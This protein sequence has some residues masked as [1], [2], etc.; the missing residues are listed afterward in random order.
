MLTTAPS[1][2]SPS[3]AEVRG[4]AVRDLA[5]TGDSQWYPR[6]VSGTYDVVV[7]DRGRFVIPRELRDRAGLTDGTPLTLVETAQGVVM[8]TRSQLRD[9]VRRDLAGLDLVG[10]LL[11]E[12]RSAA[13]AED[14]A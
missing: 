14:V 10:E 11:G 7:G 12:R 9:L 5:V 8:L 3:R 13:A 1:T 4:T 6:R 2:D